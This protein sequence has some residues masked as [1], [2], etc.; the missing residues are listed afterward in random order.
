MTILGFYGLAPNV[1]VVIANA[2]LP[3][4]FS[5]LGGFPPV[6][7]IRPYACTVV[8][9]KPNGTVASQTPP[10]PLQVL[11]GRA[12]A[13]GANCV[14]APPYVAGRHSIRFLVNNE[15]KLETYFNL[16]LPQ[17]G[18][19]PGLGIATPPTPNRPN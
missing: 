5:F 16:R 3:S 2:N 17:P 14:F 9:T 12:G 15:V 19:L 13:F 8:V 6:E 18:E 11:A 7:E 1:E 10:V 4:N